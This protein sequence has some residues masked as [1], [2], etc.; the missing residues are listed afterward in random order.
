[1]KPR[2]ALLLLCAALSAPLQAGQVRIDNPKVGHYALDYCREWAKDC[3]RPAAD[4]YCRQRG[5]YKATSFGTAKNKPPTRVIKGGQVC[6]APHCDRIS[7]VVCVTDHVYQNPKV[8]GYA[9]DYCRDWA[10]NCG[11]PAAD[12][13]CRSR[14]HNAAVDFKVQ[15]NKPP[16]R[17]ISGGRVCNAPHCDRIVSV[18]CVAK[19][20]SKPPTA[21]GHGK[22]D[23]MGDTGVYED[24]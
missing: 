18:T 11:K 12:A 19:K 8:G 15:R 9:L 5:Y 21:G 1:M 10:S 22:T 24:E 17:V 20:P 6:D 2:L 7:W 23:D 3:G 14:G 16:T 13:F 4:A